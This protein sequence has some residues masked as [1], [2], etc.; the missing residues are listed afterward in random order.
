MYK[1]SS[2]RKDSQ[3]SACSLSL[4]Y[5]SGAAR[6]LGLEMQVSLSALPER[7][8]SVFVEVQDDTQASTLNEG[9][10]KPRSRTESSATLVRI[11]PF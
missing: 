11:A 6:I 5:R 1:S 9:Q 7:W 3:V 4:P 2:A 10:I 8:S